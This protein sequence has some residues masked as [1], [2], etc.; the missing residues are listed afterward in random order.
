MNPIQNIKLYSGSFTKTE[1]IIYNF[2]LDN[3]ELISTKSIVDVAREANISKSALLRFCQKCGYKGYS[4]FKYEISRFLH[5]AS[6]N[7]N[8]QGFYSQL[9]SFYSNSIE[10]FNNTISFKSLDKFAK[11]IPEKIIK[12]YGVNESSLSARELSYRLATLGIDSEYIYEEYTIINKPLI[13]KSSN[14][15]HIYFSLSAET[16]SIRESINNCKKANAL[17]ALITQN[18]NS[19]LAKKVDYI[20][21]IPSISFPKNLMYLNPQALNFIFIEMLIASISYNTSCN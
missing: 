9:L 3:L 1:Q 15:L 5:S 6:I 17:S 18:S 14:C 12:I 13:S 10:R 20:F 4:E 16:D 2:L 21:I 11:I 8:D 19:R 7:K